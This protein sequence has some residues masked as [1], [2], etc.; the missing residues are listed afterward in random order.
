MSYLLLIT[1]AALTVGVATAQIPT[2]EP[3]QVIEDPNALE[4]TGYGCSVA[5]DGDTAAVYA[6]ELSKAYVYRRAPSEGLWFEVQQI[7]FD[8]PPPPNACFGRY[9]LALRDDT[10]LVAPGGPVLVYVD[11]SSGFTFQTSFTPA[12]GTVLDDRVFFDRHRA[13]VS[14]DGSAFVFVRSGETWTEEAELRPADGTAGEVSA[15]QGNTL[16]FSAF[17]RTAVYVFVRQGNNWIEQQKL[18]PKNAVTIGFPTFGTAA[19]VY[20]NVAV[21]GAPGD[22]EIVLP[23]PAGPG[24]AAFVF[25]RHGS[26]WTQQQKLVTTDDPNAYEGFGANVAL[27]RGLIVIGAPFPCDRTCER[28]GNVYGFV[29][30]GTEW[31]EAFAARGT[32]LFGLTLALRN[33]QLLVGGRGLLFRSIGEV[34]FYD[35]QPLPNEIRNS[36]TQRSTVP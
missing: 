29:R 20:N 36:D 17:D 11:D 31:S 8:F 1:L 35:V 25:V 22:A 18:Q 21:I 10:L 26:T 4:G 15:L 5:I 30:Q 24:G 33:G 34:K 27:E 9:E 16:L 14:G 23:P 6:G 28:T 3:I 7:E 13:A 12:D 2:L 32:H 19:A